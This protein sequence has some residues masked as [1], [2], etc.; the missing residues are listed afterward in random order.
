MDIDK[1]S[2]I[3]QLYL[4]ESLDFTDFYFKKS[5]KL[6]IIMNNLTHLNSFYFPSFV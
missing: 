5:E 1:L 6:S 4:G 3:K 2:C